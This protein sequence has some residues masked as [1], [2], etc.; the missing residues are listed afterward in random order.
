MAH[1]NRI[2]LL[3]CWPISNGICERNSELNNI[4]NKRISAYQ[5]SYNEVIAYLFHQLAAQA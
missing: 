3:N 5:S 4:C 2:R 1:T